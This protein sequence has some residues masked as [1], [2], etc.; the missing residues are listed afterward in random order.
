MVVFKRSST[1]KESYTSKKM[2]SLLV[3]QSSLGDVDNPSF[4][5]QLR[6]NDVTQI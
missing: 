5:Q 6:S 4:K 1:S 2:V 3:A